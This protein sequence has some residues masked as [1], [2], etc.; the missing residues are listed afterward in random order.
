MNKILSSAAIIIIAGGSFILGQNV[1]KRKM[2]K[3]Y[4]ETWAKMA[5]VVKVYK[6]VTKDQI[7]FG[8]K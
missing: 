1:Q 4:G 7:M 3:I 5:K 2:N 6:E 8:H